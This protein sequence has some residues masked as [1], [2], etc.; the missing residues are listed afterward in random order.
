MQ[1]KPRIIK[2]F[3][4]IFYFID[5]YKIQIVLLILIM[6]IVFF[7]FYN[8]YK[9]T[10]FPKCS[11]YVYTGYQCPGCGSQRAIYNI[12]HFRFLEA[13]KENL[14]LFLFIPFFVIAFAVDFIQLKTK[15]LLKVYNKLF[16][17]MG[18]WIVFF[19]M[20]FYWIVRNFEFYKQL[21]SKI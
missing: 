4:S 12:V 7:S 17:V 2:T 14:A 18:I 9:Q 20:I 6:L 8:P 15:L 11:F 5:R 1:N 13:I 21:M 3:N 19:L 16:S 10:F